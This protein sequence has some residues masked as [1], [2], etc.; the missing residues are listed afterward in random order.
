MLSKS[1]FIISNKKKL[2]ILFIHTPMTLAVIV[3]MHIASDTM[4][5]FIYVNLIIAIITYC[6]IVFEERIKSNHKI[7]LIHYITSYIIMFFF[8]KEVNKHLIMPMTHLWII[9]LVIVNMI[10]V[11]K[12]GNWSNKKGLL[13]FSA[14][15]LGIAIVVMTMSYL[16]EP[17]DGISKQE[18]II[19]TY[20]LEEGNERGEIV[21]LRR[22]SSTIKTREKRVYVRLL[23][24]D[25]N[26]KSYKYIYGNGS[27]KSKEELKYQFTKL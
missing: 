2:E 12:D 23:L 22:I 10:L 24:K 4:Y 20:L 19:K 13:I 25:E 11:I 27:I 14:N 16:S 1:E 18:H 3:I 5:D 21:E 9:N 8:I 7:A 17:L 26:E 15:L 6:S